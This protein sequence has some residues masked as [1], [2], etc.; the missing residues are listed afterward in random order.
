MWPLAAARRSHGTAAAARAAARPTT[1]GGRT[2]RPTSAAANGK[3]RPGW[4]P[5]CCRGLAS[6]ASSPNLGNSPLWRASGTPENTQENEKNSF[7][8]RVQTEWQRPLSGVHSIMMEKLVPAGE[9]GRCTDAQT[10][11]LHLSSRTKLQCTL[12][13]SGQIHSP[14]FIST[15]IH[16]LWF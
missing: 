11:S 1:S 3:R 13:L 9:G 12:Q 15:N 7:N 4:T 2:E 10:L 5:R 16:A 6:T 14:Y 8:L